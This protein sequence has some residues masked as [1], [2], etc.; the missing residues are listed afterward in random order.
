MICVTVGFAVPATSGSSVNTFAKLLP[1]TVPC[2]VTLSTP[3]ATGLFT[4]ASNL[5]VTLLPAGSVP[6]T[7]GENAKSGPPFKCGTAPSA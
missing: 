6:M 2:S 7:I 5:I 3:A 4:V 1:L